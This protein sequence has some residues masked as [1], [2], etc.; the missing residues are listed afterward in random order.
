MDWAVFA[1]KGD[2][3]PRGSACLCAEVLHQ[4][5]THVASFKRMPIATSMLGT[6]CQWLGRP[7]SDPPEESLT[8]PAADT[9]QS[10]RES[11]G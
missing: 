4:C 8:S 9:A 7:R 11:L 1:A 5:V 6:A 10:C 3:S 2:K